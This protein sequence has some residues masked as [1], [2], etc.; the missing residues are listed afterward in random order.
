MTK[1]RREEENRTENRKKTTTFKKTKTIDKMVIGRIKEQYNF[2][3]LI[4]SLKKMFL[5]LVFEMMV[6]IFICI[7]FIFYKTRNNFFKLN[8]T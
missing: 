8:L 5:C 3:I 1:R 2:L 7:Y 4:K 6:M